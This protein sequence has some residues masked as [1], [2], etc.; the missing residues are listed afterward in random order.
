MLSSLIDRRVSCY[1]LY[2]S[3]FLAIVLVAVRALRVHLLDLAI[4]IAFA[5]LYFSAIWNLV[6][7]A[8]RSQ[9][10]ELRLSA[11]AGILLAL[12]FA[13]MG[14]L[15]VGLG[16]PWLAT[17]AENQMRYVVLVTMA[18]A[19]VGGFVTLKEALQLAGERFYS[20]LGVAGIMLASP[21]YLV[22]ESLLIAAF[23]GAVRTEQTPDVFR[24]L[25]EFQDVL[26]FLGGVLIYVSTAAFALALRDA[27]WLGRR[28]A[29]IVVVICVGSSVSLI[30]RGLQFPDPSAVSASWYTVP[31][32]IAGIPAVPFVIPC[33][34]GV[35]LMARTDRE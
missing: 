7:R 11:M 27:G 14:L 18:S 29:A 33:L 26:M 35:V 19:V 31:G 9:N 13:M 6:G 16:P 4:G 2:G 25:S 32:F 30:L 12:P 3:P 34:L 20:T 22:G 24:S 23:A 15:W 10:Q 5:A 28:A 8:I 17:P 1:F 21:F